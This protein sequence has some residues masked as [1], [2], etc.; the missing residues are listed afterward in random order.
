M[1]I[2][3][4][5]ASSIPAGAFAAILLI[6]TIPGDFPNQG[7]EKA[8][9]VKGWRSIDFVGAFLVLATL[10]LLIAGL[11]EAASSLSWVSAKTLAPICTSAIA[12][13]TFLVSQ[14]RASRPESRV[15]P[16]FPWRFFTDRVTMGLI[17]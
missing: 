8:M 13:A 4:N 12:F 14:Y 3:S 17:L 11:E 5:I 1:G 2:C 9:Q 7:R 16:V 15:E 10:A 6:L